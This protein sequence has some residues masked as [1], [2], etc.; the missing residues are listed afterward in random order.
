M[1]DIKLLRERTSFIRDSAKAKNVELDFTHILELDQQVRTLQNNLQ[2]IAS[3][4]NEASKRIPQADES[5]RAQI[6]EEM[7]QIDRKAGEIAAQLAPLSE[8]L[9]ELLYK[10]PNPALPDVKVANNEQENEVIK[11]IGEI[12]KF[13]FAVKDHM[14]IGTKLGIIDSERAAKVSGARFSYLKGDG[15]LLE[16]ALIQYALHT[17]SIHGFI[18]ITTP[19]MIKPQAMRAMGYLE[20]GGHDEIYYLQKDN[21]YL[22]GTAEQS[23]GSMHMDETFN[24]SQ[25]PARYIGFS[26]CYRREAGSY[27]KDTK[28]ILRMHQF[29]KVEMFTYS[30]QE[31]SDVEHNLILE[32]EEIMMQ[33]LKIPYRVIKM[34]TGDLG[35]PAARKYDIEAWMPSQDTY[36]ETHSCSSCTD[37]Q[38]RRLNTKYKDNEGKSHFVHTL[39]GTAFAIGRTIIAILEN[40]QCED[41]SVNVPQ[42]LQK[43]LGKDVLIPQ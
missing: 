11:I 35:L 31:Q 3:Q 29:D 10:I 43:Y 6:I 42:V 24:N 17:A 22:I 26:P 7:R 9:D 16:F 23:V 25:L 4:K 30:T 34:V 20:H 8:E 13:N 41:G 28:G 27:G 37:F 33:A 2:H 12:P 38:A 15:A 14:E 40:Y 19:H 32:I 39:N 36:R 18:P 5:S 1:I 21:M